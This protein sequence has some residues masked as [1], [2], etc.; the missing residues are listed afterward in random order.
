MANLDIHPTKESISRKTYVA[1]C[2]IDFG[3]WLEIANNL[4]TE[5]VRGVIKEKTATEYL[6]SLCLFGVFSTQ[7]KTHQNTNQRRPHIRA[8]PRHSK[9]LPTPKRLLQL[10]SDLTLNLRKTEWIGDKNAFHH[11]EVPKS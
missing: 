6:G 3:S 1:D 5:L 7:N 10:H 11:S 4:D 8:L 9:H 2:P